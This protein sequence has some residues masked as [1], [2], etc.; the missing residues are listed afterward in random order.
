[1]KMFNL[2]T[3]G[4]FIFA[5]ASVVAIADPIPVIENPISAQS[6]TALPD[7]VG[8]GFICLSDKD[9]KDKDD[10]DSRRRD[11]RDDRDDDDLEDLLRFLFRNRRFR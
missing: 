8:E 3:I 10:K 2:L 5:V 11:R 6:M 7:S 4:L 1:M 9:D